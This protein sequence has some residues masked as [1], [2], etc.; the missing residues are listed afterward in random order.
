M[1]RLGAALLTSLALLGPARVHGQG[2]ARDDAL[3]RQV[4]STL[5][6]GVEPREASHAIVALGEPGERALVRVFERDE[7]A[8]YVRLRA[9]AL[10]GAFR[11]ESAARYLEGLVK[12][13]Q[14]EDDTL[15]ALHPARSPLVL[16]RALD[17]LSASAAQLGAR[18]DTKAVTSCLAHPDAHV[19]KSAADL[20]AKLDGRPEVDRA[21][22]Q[23]LEREPSKMVRG[24]LGRAITDRSARR[25]APR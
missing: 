24:T 17:G 19:R 18:L 3:A 11:T 23:R 7:A 10:L 12:A 16:R 20:L 5:S 2:D 6:A 13:S 14:H 21:L 15:G 9:L 22:V 25:A 4:E 1:G 8:R